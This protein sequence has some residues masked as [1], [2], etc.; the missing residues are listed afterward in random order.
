MFTRPRALIISTGLAG[1]ILL[2]ACGGLA[3]LGPTPDGEGNVIFVHANYAGTSQALNVD[4][5]NLERVEGPCDKN[6][7]EE[8]APTWGD[9]VSSVRV[10]PG[11][12]AT[13]YRDHDF[14][15]QGVT[16][17]SDTPSLH[18]LPGPCD[19]SF[20]DCVSSIRVARQ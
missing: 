20:N 5:A 17:T 9:C 1:S 6:R 2:P 15:G 7:E 8:G 16:I 18:D 13:L 14:R 4:V 3:T 12:S 19:G 10:H 11:W